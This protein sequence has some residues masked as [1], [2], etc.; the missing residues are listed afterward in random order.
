MGC[1]TGNWEKSTLEM[2]DDEEGLS[3]PTRRVKKKEKEKKK[4]T[5]GNYP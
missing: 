3:S 4:E 5:F 2:W 1:G